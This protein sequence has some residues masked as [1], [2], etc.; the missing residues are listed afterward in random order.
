[1]NNT[2]STINNFIP[3]S[4][5]LFK[6]AFW[7]QKR[8]Y[9]RFEAWLDLLV[10]ARFDAGEARLLIGGIVVRWQRGELIASVRFLGNRWGWS[11]TKVERFLTMLKSEN[12]IKSRTADGT[13]Q[14]IISI[15]NYATYNPINKTAGQP[16]GQYRDSIGTAPG[17]HRDETNKENKEQES[18][19]RTIYRRFAHLLLYS[20]EFLKLTQTGYSKTQIDQVLDAIEN[21]KNNK[22]YISLYLTA[23]KWLEADVAGGV[24]ANGGRIVNIASAFQEAL[25]YG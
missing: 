23:K 10:S 19:E 9:S 22:K 13:L 7:D 2:K 20:D 12:M 17:Q 14:T 4:R 25:Q 6:H 15:C 18:K 8:A 1:M 3:I 21:Y 5:K 16:S 24:N 11:K